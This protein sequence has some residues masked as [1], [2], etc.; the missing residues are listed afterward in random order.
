MLRFNLNMSEPAPP[1][2]IRQSKAYLRDTD[3]R[4]PLALAAPAHF[5]V[6]HAASVHD[7][8]ESDG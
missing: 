3:D 5:A 4:T 8:S 1:A 2:E 7:K 6:T